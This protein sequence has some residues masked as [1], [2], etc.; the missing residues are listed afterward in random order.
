MNCMDCGHANPE[1]VKF[2]L[3]CGAKLD[4]RTCPACGEALP[5]VAKFCGECGA[6]VETAQRNVVPVIPPVVQ[7]N[8]PPAHVATPRGYPPRHLADRMLASRSAMEGERKYVTVLIGDA[9]AKPDPTFGRGMSLALRDVRVLS[10][11][12]KAQ[13]NW[14]EAARTYAAEHV[15]YQGALHAIEQWFNAL[16]WDRGAQAD[17]RR[18][19]VRPEIARTGLPAVV[20]LGPESGLSVVD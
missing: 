9:V 7:G 14:Q 12:L 8:A 4:A 6:K 5:P 11:L 2:C 13:T 10:D 19:R 17:A 3:E 16:L 18:K 15:R 1:G 20:G